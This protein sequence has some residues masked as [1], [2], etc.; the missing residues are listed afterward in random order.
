M[1]KFSGNLSS[2]HYG[3]AQVPVSFHMMCT[4]LLIRNLIDSNI[5]PIESRHGNI[6]DKYHSILVCT[7]RSCNGFLMFYRN[8]FL[9]SM[10]GATCRDD[11]IKWKYFPCYWSFV[12][13]IHRWPVNSPHKCQWRGALM[14][15]LICTWMN[16]W[17][18]NGEVGDLRRHH[19]HYDV[20]VIQ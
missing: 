15:S 19:T 18:N 8:G 9:S 14:L 20:T 12:R 17:V 4:F 16:G 2:I 6:F 7:K 5:R 11:V 10:D 3:H 1:R 13:A